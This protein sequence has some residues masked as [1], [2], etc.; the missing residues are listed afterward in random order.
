MNR[1][2]KLS[3]ENTEDH[4]TEA[5]AMTDAFLSRQ[6][7][8]RK[9][10]IHLRLLAEETLGMVRAFT[11]D[12]NADFWLEEDSGEYRIRLIVTTFMD[13]KKKKE[14]LSLSTSGKNAAAKGIMGKIGDMIETGLLSSGNS[15]SGS[16]DEGLPDVPSWMGM[17]MPS[18]IAMTAE[19]LEWSLMSYRDA[20]DNMSGSD[21]EPEEPWDEL[22]RSIVASL[23]KDVVVGIRH[24]QADITIVAR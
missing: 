20:L 11:G 6:K 21:T 24:D 4:V 18:E 5:L 14:L 13:K 10:A 2:G 16:D 12:Y 1:S 8:D 3:I 7:I 15:L 17:G 9:S 23:A 19:S 22:E